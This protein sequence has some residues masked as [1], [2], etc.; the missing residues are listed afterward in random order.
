MISPRRGCC[1]IGV[2]P[3]D[4]G[5]DHI[6]LGMVMGKCTAVAQNGHELDMRAAAL[7]LIDFDRPVRNLNPDHHQ[8]AVAVPRTQVAAVLGGG[9][10]N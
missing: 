2:R 6:S 7:H 3:C 1:S 5:G 4:N 8:L 10:T 9:L